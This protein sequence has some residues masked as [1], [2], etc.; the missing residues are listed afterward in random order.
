M[1]VSKINL[2]KYFHHNFKIYGLICAIFVIFGV[3]Y[4]TTIFPLIFKLML[5]RQ[6]ELRPGAE[7]RAMWE[8]I[9]FYLGFKIYLFNITNPN[10]VLNGNKPILEEIG[11][12][13]FE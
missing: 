10:E 1:K 11:P 9:P 5:K 8:I 3:L 7:M 2:T 4:G 6:T 13:F 12:Y